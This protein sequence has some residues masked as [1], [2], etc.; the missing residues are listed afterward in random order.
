MTR[1][2]TKWNSHLKG[3]MTSFLSD[4]TAPPSVTRYRRTFLGSCSAFFRE[5][6]KPTARLKSFL[7]IATRSRPAPRVVSWAEVTHAVCSRDRSLW[8]KS[9][10]DLR[11]PLWSY[12]KAALLSGGFHVVHFWQ[13][14]RWNSSCSHGIVMLHS[15]LL[16]A[17]GLSV[18]MSSM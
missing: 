9:C 11:A 17:P 6:W 2:E 12:A 18:K 14:F 8:R 1:L 10:F 7:V 15:K 3:S 5:G 13:I 16:R 4:N